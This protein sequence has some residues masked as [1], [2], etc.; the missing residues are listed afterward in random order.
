MAQRLRVRPSALLGIDDEYVAYCLDEAVVE[1]GGAVQAAVDDVKEHK[2]PKVTAAKKLE[3][4][5]KYLGLNEG[6]SK[7]KKFAA[8]S[9]TK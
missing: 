4:L 3:T 1:F 2:N 7:V 8:P 5:H 6:P 9:A